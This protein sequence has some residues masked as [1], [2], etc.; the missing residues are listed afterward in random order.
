M[1]KRSKSLSATIGD[2]GRVTLPDDVRKHLGIEAGDVVMI[3][4]TENGTAE[5]IPAALIP[6]DQLWFTY[7]E[8]QARMREATADVDA[9]RTTRARNAAEVRAHLTRLKKSS[10]SE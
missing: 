5:L 10:D 6:R 9:G 2:K 8:V 1:A 4:L 7:P 3:D